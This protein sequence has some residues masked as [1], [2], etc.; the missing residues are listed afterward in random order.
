VLLAYHVAAGLRH[1]DRPRSLPGDTIMNR[2]FLHAVTCLSLASFD[3]AP[4]FSQSAT[5]IVGGDLS[6]L[7][8]GRSW[9]IS[10]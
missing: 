2:L 9:G 3:I 6:A 10:Y 8:N 1:R 4:A 7:T 5:N